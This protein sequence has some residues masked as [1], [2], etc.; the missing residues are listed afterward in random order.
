ENEV[1]DAP[2]RSAILVGMADNGDRIA[3]LHRILGPAHSLQDRDRC[4]LESVGHGTSSFHDRQLD[5]DMRVGPLDLL[6]RAF[7]ADGLT[8]IERGKGV[9]RMDRQRSDEEHKSCYGG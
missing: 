7:V 5:P 1:L 9:M 4:T 3:R 6:H 2:T 8:C